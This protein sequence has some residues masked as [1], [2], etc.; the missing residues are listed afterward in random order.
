[1]LC[2]LIRIASNENTQY[3]IFNIEKK[4][5]LYY[6]KTAA[7]GFFQGTQRRVWNSHGKGAL[8]VRAT[9]GLINFEQLQKLKKVFKK[10]GRKN[11]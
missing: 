3:T 8:S 1:M 4:I 7:I 9:G 6:P 5:S 11:R 10:V 2:V